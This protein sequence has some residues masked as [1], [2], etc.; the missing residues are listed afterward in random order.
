MVTAEL[1]IEGGGDNRQQHSKALRIRFRQGWNAF[2]KSAGLGGRMPKVV[3]GGGRQQTFE[4]FAIAIAE[5]HPSIVPLLLVDSETPVKSGHSVWQHLQVRDGWNR[6]LNAGDD[7]A[8]LMVQA[9][10]TWFIADRNS[11]QRYFGAKFNE[12]AFRQWPQL[13][14][15]PKATV[16]DALERAT[17]K[18]YAKGKV[19]FALLAQIDPA[20]VEA[21]CPH[22]KALLDRLRTLLR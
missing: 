3:R 16:F 21:A 20:L 1:Y 2:F 9:M 19:S 10:E 5:G 11:L 14:A 15:V 22:S 6:P 7:Q 17:D 8:F 12:N 13:E 18:G 4:R